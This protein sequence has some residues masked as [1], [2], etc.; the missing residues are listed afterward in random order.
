[1]DQ[2]EFEILSHDD[3]DIEYE[4]GGTEIIQPS[5]RNLLSQ[6]TYEENGCH[7]IRRPIGPA[8]RH[9]YDDGRRALTH[10]VVQVYE[11]NTTPH[12]KIRDAVSGVFWPKYKV[13]SYS[14]YLFFKVFWSVGENGR[15][16][17]LVLFFNTPEEYERHML[18]EV[19]PEI[20]SQ[21]YERRNLEL[22]KDKN[23][24]GDFSII[25]GRRATIVK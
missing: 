22:K 8:Y 25:S 23:F 7:K 16:D 17:P 19:S 4:V 2:E 14:E 13:G 12:Y 6:T 18:V 5:K 11:T 3:S 1:M 20:K 24:K 9:L 21:W 10:I 15:K